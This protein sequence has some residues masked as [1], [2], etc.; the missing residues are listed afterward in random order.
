[1]VDLNE[2]NRIIAE[3]A[4]N[5]KIEV[6][7]IREALSEYVSFNDEYAEYREIAKEATEKY[8][9]KYFNMHAVTN[10]K[11]DLYYFKVTEI[12]FSE[13]WTPKYIVRGE[14]FRTGGYHPKGR[15]TL[16]YCYDDEEGLSIHNMK[17][18][19]SFDVYIVPKEK[20]ESDILRKMNFIEKE[21]RNIL[22][23]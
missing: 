5:F 2:R 1:M 18:V 19:T 14:K 3:L 7:D 6:G 16:E 13:A 15:Y 23:D 4:E 21:W 8:K 10:N 12:K 9:G 22:N 20:V 17:D 11:V